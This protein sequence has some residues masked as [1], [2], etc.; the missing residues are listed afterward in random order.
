[1]D[2]MNADEQPWCPSS[3]PDVDGSELLGVVGGTVTE[4]RVSYVVDHVPVTSR[5]LQLAEPVDPTEVFRFAA[6]CVGSACQ[7][8]DGSR[9]SLV[10]KIATF[11]PPATEDLPPCILRSRCRWWREVGAEACYRCPI[12]V[13]REHHPTQALAS[14]ADPSVRPGRASATEEGS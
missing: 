10:Q 3:Q 13:T 12:I 5:I 9:C 8:F 11:V 2:E 1:L 6:P 14:A 7:H 4:P